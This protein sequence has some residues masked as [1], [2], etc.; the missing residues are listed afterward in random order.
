MLRLSYSQ[1]NCWK[2]CKRQYCYKYVLKLKEKNVETKWSDFGKAMHQVL[3][4]FHNKS[5]L[6]WQDNCIFQWDKYKLEDRMDF[7]LFKTCVINGLVLDFVPTHTEQKIFIRIGENQFVQYLDITESNKGIILDWKSGTY[8]KDKETDYKKQ[9]ICYSYGYFRTYNKF[10]KEA[11]IFFNKPNKMIIFHVVSDDYNGNE[12]KII[13]ESEILAYK[14]SV[15]SMAC[16]I[17]R[18]KETLKNSDDWEQNL[19]VCYPF[20]GY[21]YICYGQTDCFKYKITIKNGNGFLHGNVTPTLLEGIDRLT[22]FDLPSKYYMQQAILAKRNG[23]VKNIEEIGRVH[24]FNKIHRM[25]PIGFLNKIKK[26]LRDYCEYNHKIL[27]LEIEDLRDKEIIKSK[28]NIMPNK[29]ITNKILRDYQ[30]KAIESF[31]YN[32]GIGCVVAGTGAGKTYLATEIIRLINTKT[33]WIIDRKELLY[34]TKEVIENLL[35]IKMGIVGDGKVEYE[36]I[37]IATIQT[38]HKNID[39]HKKYL[40]SINFVVADEFHKTA[41]ES[42][43]NVFSELKNTKYR[44]GLTGTPKREDGKTPIM[45]SLLGDIIFSI[46]AKELIEKEYLMKPKI[47]FYKVKHGGQDLE[48][49]EDYKISI[50]EN[51]HRNNMIVKIIEENKDKKILVLAKLVENHG[52]KL[53]NL[54]KDSYYIHGSLNSEK[55]KKYM[56]AFKNN[57]FGILIATMSIA[58]TGLDI[59]DLQI[60]INVAG[61][62]A[63][64]GSIQSLGRVLRIIEGKESAKYIDFIDV[65]KHTSKHSR[66]RI[67]SFKNEGHDVEII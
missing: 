1:L 30:I 60:I 67:K 63:N 40:N 39:K 9:L 59:P 61:N 66:A 6:N 8:T 48:Y 62:K 10:P 37:T 42:Y 58:S 13:K 12:Q 23:M 52:K 21:K 18:S 31:I 36:D 47:I 51:E 26:I 29:L 2:N 16:E 49:P 14:E 7:N 41:A 35:G 17:K 34:Q 57:K 27:D 4:E 65:G 19:K 43:Q 28:L 64:I 32:D 38:L 5:N 56:N 46:S 24:L 53:N 3:E 20:C 50:A 11:R 25:F 33:L 45:H 15:I 54:I 55:R 44:L 22:R